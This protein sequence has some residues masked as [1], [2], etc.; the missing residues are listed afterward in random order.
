MIPIYTRYL[1]PA[2]YGILELLD[3]TV[4]ILGII[5][6]VRLAMSMVRYYYHYETD[7]DR[8]EVFTTALISTFSLSVLSLILLELFSK[9]IAVMAI[10]KA[11][12][13]AYL[14]IIFISL[15]IQNIYLIS[16]NFI[17]IQKRSILY[18]SLS[19]L[20]LVLSL[21]MNILFLVVFKMGVYGI[22]ISMLIAKSVNFLIVVPM[23]LKNIPLRF[24]TTKL[25]EMIKLS[26]P[27]IPAAFGMLIMHF[28]DRFF[29]KQ[30]CT[31]DELGIYSLGY[32]FGMIISLLISGP[33]FRIWNVQRFEIA[34]QPGAKYVFSK[35]LTYFTLV[36][37]FAGL[38][39]SVLIDDVLKI[40]ATPAFQDAKIVV[41]LIVLSYMLFGIANFFS[42]GIMLKYKT[43]YFSYIQLAVAGLNLLFNMLLIP[44]YGVYGA[45]LSTLLSF[46]CLMFFSYI[47]SQGLYKIGFEYF[48]IMQIAAVSGTLFWI[49]CLIET[50]IILSLLLK[51]GLIASFPVLLF[52][53]GFFSKE[54]I[55][56]GRS[57]MKKTFE[58]L[59]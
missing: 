4:E 13:A 30:H 23:T 7:E 47:A 35:M 46:F 57:F 45:A 53:I 1:T 54:E 56:K 29:I 19:I 16:E 31:L 6:G 18:S 42:L 8:N 40:I 52:F 39:I 10:G 21:S 3:L 36:I 49:S 28:S 59:V 14:Q 43:K 11:E 15:A 22:L 44:N 38:T 34:K 37:S 51:V 17:V 55:V 32:K 20:T 26:L 27:M 58:P 2:D 24:N 33:I 48:R 25:I 41:P 5:V 12:H 50:Q 9:P